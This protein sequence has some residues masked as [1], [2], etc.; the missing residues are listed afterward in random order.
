[1]ENELEW[2]PDLRRSEE[3]NK[4]LK[5]GNKNYERIFSLN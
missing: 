2:H 4:S 3:K 5:I 1:M